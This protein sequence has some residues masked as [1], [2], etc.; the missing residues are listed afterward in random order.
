M[1][2]AQ[3]LIDCGVTPVI[4]AEFAEPLDAACALFSIDSPQRVA[5]FLAQ[6][7]YESGM[8]HVMSENTN[9][10]HPERLV[11]VFGMSMADAMRLAGKPEAIANFVYANR[12][13]N[14]NEASGDGWN[15]R[16]RAPIELTGKRS[17]SYAG[18]ALGYDFVKDPDQVAQPT[19]G[20]LV[21]AWFWHVNNLNVLADKGDDDG[22]TRAVNGKKMLGA[23][24]RKALSGTFLKVLTK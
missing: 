7:A 15:Y 6:C 1:I 23:A 14:G 20:S 18:A 11:E 12:N 24:A 10:T 17:Y 16:G 13:G 19:Q 8:F 22:C 4:A 5:S 21:S 3:V 9:Y 2:S